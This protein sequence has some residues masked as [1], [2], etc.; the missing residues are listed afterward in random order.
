MAVTG[1]AKFKSLVADFAATAAELGHPVQEHL[2]VAELQQRIASAALAIGVSQQWVLSAYFD[3]SWGRDMARQVC[4]EVSS[5]AAESIDRNADP[6]PAGQL[7][8]LAASSVIA[9]LGMALQYFAGNQE[10]LDGDSGFSINDAGAAVFVLAETVSAAQGCD[11]AMADVQGHIVAL[12]QDNLEAFRRCL[13]Q[14]RWT[15]PGS[16]M[17]SLA[18]NTRFCARA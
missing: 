9:T 1:S 18:P 17:S 3:D 8:V 14:G 5:A 12:A 7:T 6:R 11:R 13:L 2:V 16:E 15:H 10:R 4:S